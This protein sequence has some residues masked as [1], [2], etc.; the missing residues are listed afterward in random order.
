MIEI[1]SPI[2]GLSKGLPVDKE[3]PAT[4]GWMN[5]V[6]PVDTLEKKLRLGKRP[7]LRKWGAGTQVGQAEMPVVAMCVVAAIL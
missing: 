2:R 7:P 5:N 4:S 6:R 1:I 3:Q